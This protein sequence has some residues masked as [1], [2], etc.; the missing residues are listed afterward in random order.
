MTDIPP[1]QALADRYLQEMLEA[2]RA[3]DFTAWCARWDDEELEGF[4][5]ASFQQDLDEMSELLGPY[6]S[7]D[8]L[9]CLTPPAGTDPDEEE[10]P[11]LRFVWK[12]SYERGDA[13][14]DVGIVHLNGA[15]RVYRNACSM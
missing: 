7:R 12:A 5:E 9:G 15:W 10:L 14:F 13:M 2:E 3:R 4:D 8:Y 11:R 1:E 6:R